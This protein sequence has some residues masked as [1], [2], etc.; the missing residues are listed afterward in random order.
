MFFPMNGVLMNTR[1]FSLGL[2]V[3]LAVAIASPVALAGPTNVPLKASLAA[4]ETLIPGAF[5]PPDD[6]CFGSFAKGTTTVIGKAS[7][8]GR[9]SGGATD[10]INVLVPD[11][12]PSFA[13]TNGALTLTAADGE[14]LNVTYHGTF[15]PV[16]IDPSDPQT[17]IYAIT[18]T[19]EVKGGTGRFANATGQGVLDGLEKIGVLPP[20]PAQL[21]LTGTISY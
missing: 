5:L 13:F 8:L 21:E 3:L 7:H 11:N 16:G 15:T 12:P 1:W 10:C 2:A 17:V 14:Q 20:F 6:V 4:Q 19:F 18:G 9:V